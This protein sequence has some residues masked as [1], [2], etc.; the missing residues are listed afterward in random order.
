MVMV[1]GVRYLSVGYVNEQEGVVRMY[2][3]IYRILLCIK[4]NAGV[5]PP[6][7]YQDWIS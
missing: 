4:S 3:V 5:E 6:K 7:I 1:D 2:H